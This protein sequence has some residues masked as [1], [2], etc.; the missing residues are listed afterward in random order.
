[1]LQWACNIPEVFTPNIANSSFFPLILLLIHLGESLGPGARPILW[2]LWLYHQAGCVQCRLHPGQVL[3]IVTS[4]SVL[5]TMPCQWS[6]SKEG[7]LR[8]RVGNKMGYLKPLLSG[9]Q[10]RYQGVVSCE[11]KTCPQLLEGPVFK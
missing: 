9:T 5:T 10:W 8:W 3:L 2:P 7:R 1:M 4:D 11:Q 6:L